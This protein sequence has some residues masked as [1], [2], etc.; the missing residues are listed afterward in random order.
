MDSALLLVLAQQESNVPHQ[1]S[2]RAHW[3]SGPWEWKPHDR[4]IHFRFSH[5]FGLFKTIAH[6]ASLKIKTLF[7][8]GTDD[9]SEP[10]TRSV[11]HM[12]R[13]KRESIELIKALGQPVVEAPAV[14]AKAACVRL[15]RLNIAHTIA[16]ED[17]G[18][19]AFGARSVVMNL[20]TNSK[21]GPK[22]LQI[23]ADK[24][25]ETLGITADQ[26][27]A[28]CHSLISLESAHF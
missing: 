17:I 2:R 21:Y 13:C 8:F 23:Q 27:K 9:I 1:C 19:L 24:I 20:T 4:F 28:C 16:T 18:A 14:S 25:T 12:T 6:L 7:V 10:N 3:V 22:P 11:D 26:V 15:V 5:L